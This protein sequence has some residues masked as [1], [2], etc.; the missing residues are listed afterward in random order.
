MAT[1]APSL[2]EAEKLKKENATY[3]KRIRMLEAEIERL[4]RKLEM[5]WGES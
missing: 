2:S 1:Q 5:T 4:R 3:Q